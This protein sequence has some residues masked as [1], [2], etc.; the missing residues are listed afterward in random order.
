MTPE[1]T[2]LQVFSPPGMDSYVKYFKATN[3]LSINDPPSM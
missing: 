3:Y 2:K 1:K